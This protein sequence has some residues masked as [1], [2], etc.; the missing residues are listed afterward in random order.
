MNDAEAK[1]SAFERK[2]KTFSAVSFLTP[3]SKGPTGIAERNFTSTHI[4]NS[5]I[6]PT[7]V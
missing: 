4:T 3:S 7:L 6:A 1:A 5:Q 2:W